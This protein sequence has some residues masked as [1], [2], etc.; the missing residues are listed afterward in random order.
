MRKAETKAEEEADI[1]IYDEGEPSRHLSS[2]D[3]ENQETVEGIPD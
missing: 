3:H 2:S 1:M